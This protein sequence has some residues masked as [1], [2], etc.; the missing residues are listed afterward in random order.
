M[1]K[2]REAKD[3]EA[4]GALKAAGKNAHWVGNGFCVA[5]G[6]GFTQPATS[7]QP[8]AVPAQLGG[9]PTIRPSPQWHVPQTLG[10]AQPSPSPLGNQRGG[11]LILQH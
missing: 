1:D 11:G 6:G 4:L 9:S 3:N 8:A 2:S 10:G 5:E 7:P